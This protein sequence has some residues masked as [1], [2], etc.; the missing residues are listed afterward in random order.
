M[1]EDDTAT[2]LAVHEAVCNER[3]NNI[4]SMLR[5]GDKRMSKIEILLYLLI[6][7]VLLGPG[8]AAE[9]VR[10]LIGV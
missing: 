4:H 7:A 3:Y 8:T 9:F 6:V 1:S 10:K 2:R 5:D